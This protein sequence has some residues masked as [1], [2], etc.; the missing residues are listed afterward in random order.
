MWFTETPWPPI[1]ILAVIAA[2]SA[3]AYITTQRSWH[4]AT[5]LTLA[6]LGV[7][8]YFVEDSIVTER[9][10]V[11]QSIAEMVHAF[12]Q[13]DVDRVAGFFSQQWR[14]PI[15]LPMVRQL[16]FIPVRFAV[17]QA[18][19]LVEAEGDLRLTDVSVEMKNNDTRATSHFRV[20]GTFR[21]KNYGDVG[22]Q[23]TRWEFDWQ[24]E[25]GEWKVIRIERLDPINRTP[26]KIFEPS[27]RGN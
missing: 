2:I 9:E 27:T 22:H 5:V 8:I 4:L 21:V 26:M 25:G 10:R 20:N 6:I 16:D 1:I 12:E 14:V 13:K 11:E 18:M 24:K 3:A 19:D 17:Q 7:V 15:E 23:P